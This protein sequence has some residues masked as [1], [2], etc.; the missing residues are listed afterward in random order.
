MATSG[1]KLTGDYQPQSCN[2]V[3]SKPHS[4]FLLTDKEPKSNLSFSFEYFKQIDYFG[5][6][7]QKDV[8]FVSL[9]DRLKDLS[10][11]SS[12]ILGD[13]TF[14]NQYRFHPIN[15]KQTNIP[16]QKKDL[17]W[18][19]KKYID[20]DEFEILQFELS[21]S[22]GRI[23]GFMNENCDVFYVVL[24]DP[25][26]NIQ[27]SK[28]YDYKVDGTIVCMTD[29]EELLNKQKQYKSQKA[30]CQQKENCPI[31]FDNAAEHNRRAERLLWV[32]EELVD[33]YEKYS[34]WQLSVEF[35]EFLL[36]KLN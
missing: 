13:V 27:P 36:N 16:V 7:G 24:L 1:K 30:S 8:W 19:P 11:K 17:G 5:V 33:V 23:V 34:T 12:E 18:L 29:Y 25:K 26:H 21:K 9:L 32:D 6:K 3:A 4:K 2:I 28:K 31:Q 10:A 14:K 22:T 20:N 35:E 15:W